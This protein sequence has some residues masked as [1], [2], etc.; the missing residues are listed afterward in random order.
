MCGWLK[1]TRPGP[2]P[3]PG[4]LRCGY[5]SGQLRRLPSSCAFFFEGNTTDGCS[6]KEEEKKRDQNIQKV[7]S[8]IGCASQ[9]FFFFFYVWAQPREEPVKPYTFSSHSSLLLCPPV[10]KVSEAHLTSLFNNTV[11]WIVTLDYI[12]ISSWFLVPAGRIFWIIITWWWCCPGADSGCKC[13]KKRD[14]HLSNA[15]WVTGQVRKKRI[16]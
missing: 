5:R 9:P 3:D 16:S 12:I 11:H 13:W 8:I 1:P 10:H 6:H 2:R 7:G 4:R 14:R 15:D